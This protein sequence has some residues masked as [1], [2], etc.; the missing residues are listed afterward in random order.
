MLGNHSEPRRRIIIQNEHF[1]IHLLYY[2]MFEM[3]IVIFWAAEF[4]HARKTGCR[5]MWFLMWKGEKHGDWR[6]R[7]RHEETGSCRL[8]DS[9]QNTDTDLCFLLLFQTSP[10]PPPTSPLFSLTHHFSFLTVPQN[11][12]LFTCILYDKINFLKKKK[13]ILFEKQIEYNFCWIY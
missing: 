8:L 7:Y 11:F 9:G 5:V 12:S 2:Y 3:R 1:F 13:K 10:A 6:L 4:L